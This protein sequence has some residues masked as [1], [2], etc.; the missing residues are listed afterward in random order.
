[1]IKQTSPSPPEIDTRAEEL[2]ELIRSSKEALENQDSIVQQ[3]DK[4]LN[5]MHR[6]G[7]GG[8]RSEYPP[9]PCF[10]NLPFSK[11]NINYRC[12]LNAILPTFFPNSRQN[13]IEFFVF[14]D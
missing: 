11:K 4:H 3:L 6:G 13:K 2:N 1:L 8:V 9:E 14:N 7:T 5:E 12:M 10:L